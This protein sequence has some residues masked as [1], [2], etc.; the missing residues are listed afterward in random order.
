MRFATIH[1]HTSRFVPWGLKV[2]KIKPKSTFIFF[3][4]SFLSRYFHLTSL[5]FLPQLYLAWLFDWKKGEVW[6][7]KLQMCPKRK[8]IK[9]SICIGV[10]WEGGTERDK[11]E[12]I[13]M[14]W[15]WT[16]VDSKWLARVWGYRVGVKVMGGRKAERKCV[17]DIRLANGRV[18]KKYI[19]E[20]VIWNSLLKSIAFLVKKERKFHNKK[21]SVGNFLLYVLCVYSSTW[22]PRKLSQTIL[23]HV[24][25]EKMYVYC[26]QQNGRKRVAN[27]LC[28]S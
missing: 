20:S 4:F 11:R 25:G 10:A 15:P 16:D 19:R 9:K 18:G 5:T 21:C 24:R 13:E 23:F 1:T 26:I 6:Y 2:G 27:I 28:D 17:T 22:T 12:N 3:A 7:W 8:K 14:E